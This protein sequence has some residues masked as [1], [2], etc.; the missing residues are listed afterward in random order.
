MMA[1][2]ASKISDAGF[3]ISSS[4]AEGVKAE[5][6]EAAVYAQ[7][8]ANRLA[9]EAAYKEYNAWAKEFS[10]LSGEEQEARKDEKDAAEKAFEEAQNAR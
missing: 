1:R 3:S 7:K 6:I 9:E 10:A 4:E 2:A 5:A 8:E